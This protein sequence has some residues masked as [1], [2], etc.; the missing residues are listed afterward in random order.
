MN[1]NYEFTMIDI[2]DSGRQSDGGEILITGLEFF[3]DWGYCVVMVNG[4]YPLFLGGK[5][6]DKSGDVSA[7]PQR[8]RN[9]TVVMFLTK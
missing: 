2:G 3:F 8:R 1:A 7:Y 5:M 9:V 6:G 4:D